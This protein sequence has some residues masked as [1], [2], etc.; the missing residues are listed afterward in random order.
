M[1]SDNLVEKFE[2]QLKCPIC[3]QIFEEPKLLLC[4]HVLCKKCLTRL[5]VHDEEKGMAFINCPVCRHRTPVSSGNVAKLRAAFLVEQFLEILNDLKSKTSS[6]SFESQEKVDLETLKMQK[7]QAVLYC[8]K[9]RGK[10]MEYFCE[11]CEELVCSHCVIKR[12]PHADHEYSLLETNFDKYVH[13]VSPYFSPL[14]RQLEKIKEGIVQMQARLQAVSEQQD[15][16]RERIHSSFQELRRALDAREGELIQELDRIAGDKKDDLVNQKERLETKQAKVSSCL[17]FV[18]DSL[19][20]NSKAEVLKMTSTTLAQVKETITLL[21]PSL[22]LPCTDANMSF[23]PPNDV[24]G[25]CQEFGS[26]NVLASPLQCYAS[27]N[28]LEEAKIG[29]SSLVDLE[30]VGIKSPADCAKFSTSLECEIK[31]ELTG[32]ATSGT[33]KQV[34]G[35]LFRVTYKPLIKGKHLLQIKLR[36][37]H[38]K[39]S[40]FP[41]MVSSIDVSVKTRFKPFV[42]T[43]GL[44]KP[45]G[46]AIAP[47][48][49]LVVSE[50]ENRCI[51][52]FSPS[53]SLLF[54][55]GSKPISACQSPHGV[56]VDAKS[57]IYVVD[58]LNHCIQKYNCD[59]T[60]IISAGSKGLGDRKF[61]FPTGISYNKQNDLLYVVDASHRVQVMDMDMKFVTSFGSCGNRNGQFRTPWGVACDNSGKVYVADVETKRIQIFSPDGDFLKSFNRCTSNGQVSLAVDSSGHVYVSEETMHRVSVFSSDGKLLS[62]IGS[63][64]KKVGELSGPLGL[65]VDTAGVVYVCD[66]DN[67]RIQMYI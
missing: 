10:E 60:L 31:S 22:L 32:E 34:D 42:V 4:F 51:S 35:N 17:G 29:E 11:S 23:S 45:Y 6:G 64:G 18:R 47:G 43:S 25:V 62:S 9:H 56:A 7:K 40:P 46:I 49:N 39:G 48:N 65:A 57:N 12:E 28:G 67:G 15:Q 2:E 27:G 66:G 59:G 55:A 44:K 24:V 58:S 14:Q 61:Q 50:L 41:M 8:S 54:S 38:I 1:M 5:V 26:I 3:F 30:V 21:E 63:K 37:E 13:E 19:K 52:V 16:V 53:G 36:G 33:L 20:T